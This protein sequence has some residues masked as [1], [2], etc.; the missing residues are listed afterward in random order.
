MIYRTSI[1]NG[2]SD[3][4]SNGDSNS[5]N[6]YSNKGK[7]V[8]NIYIQDELGTIVNHQITPM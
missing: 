5:D 7:N 3:S 6:N 4:N 1:D 2:N 8:K